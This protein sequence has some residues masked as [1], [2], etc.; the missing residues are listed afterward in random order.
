MSRKEC[1]RKDAAF[2]VANEQAQ[3]L[4]QKLMDEVKTL[5]ETAERMKVTFLTIIEE[6]KTLKRSV[7][8]F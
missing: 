1:S 5:K 2:D 3:H 4:Q 6:N 8:I 7:S